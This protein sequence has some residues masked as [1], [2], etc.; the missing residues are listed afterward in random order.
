LARCWLVGG[1]SSGFTA[2]YVSG[3]AA[4]GSMFVS[5]E[6]ELWF[7]G[8]LRA[9]ALGSMFVSW[10]VRDLVSGLLGVGGSGIGLDVR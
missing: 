6:Q 8:V 9:A 4:L 10:W 3:A 7:H 1:G 2:S 5:W